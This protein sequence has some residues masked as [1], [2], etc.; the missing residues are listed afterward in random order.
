MHKY[1][2]HPR[3]SEANPGGH[4]GAVVPPVWF[5]E[6]RFVLLEEIFQETGFRHFIARYEIDFEKEIFYGS[7]VMVETFVEK[8]GNS[9][10]VLVQKLI[11]N[12][13]VCAIGRT[14]V[15]HVDKKSRRSKPISQEMRGLLEPFI[16]V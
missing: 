14:V 9:S 10:L 2:I 5:E 8:I 13:D 12:D 7:D 3:I 6:A 1:S 4:I 15:V 11:Q 16:A